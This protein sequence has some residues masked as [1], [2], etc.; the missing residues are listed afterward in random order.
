MKIISMKMLKVI[1]VEMFFGLFL[2]LECGA[3][4]E[5]AVYKVSAW[6][7]G[8]PVSLDTASSRQALD[9]FNVVWYF[10]QKNGSI[11]RVGENLS[12]VKTA[13]AKGLKVFASL[14]NMNLQ[15]YEFDPV[16]ANSILKT[17]QTRNSHIDKI[18]SICVKGGYDGIDLDWESLYPKDKDRFSLFVEALAMKLHKVG[19]QLS[20]AVHPK[21]SEPGD[22]DG[23]KSQDWKRLGAAVDEFKIMTYDYSGPWSAPGPVAPPEWVDQVLTH[24]EA[25]V[26]ASKIMM[27]MP[28]YGYDFY[29]GTAEPRTWEESKALYTQ[30]NSAVLSDSS[31]EATFTYYDSLQVN[32][33]V[34]FQDR[35]SISIKLHILL[36]KHRAIRGICI[37]RMGQEDPQFWDE[38]NLSLKK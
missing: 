24:A 37:W 10:S 35:L 17:S 5:A 20:I 11:V 29:S 31:G 30:Y 25:L 3:Y 1:T 12:M 13:R 23:P 27:G 28:F 8:D 36:D 9:E 38:V 21:V 33:L 18:Y 26:P 34:F 4:I 6:S 22:W 16:I 7:W 14:S 15:T 32:H 2:I 19:K